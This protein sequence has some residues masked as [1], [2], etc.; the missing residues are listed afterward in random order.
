[1]ARPFT[2]ARHARVRPGAAKP[3]VS[4]NLITQ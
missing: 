3:A 4:R 2:L 1:M